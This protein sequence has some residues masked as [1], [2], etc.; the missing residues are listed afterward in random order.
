MIGVCCTLG[1]FAQ[2]DVQ[3]AGRPVSGTGEKTKALET[4]DLSG[5]S[6]GLGKRPQKNRSLLGNPLR[7]GGK[8]YSRGVGT[9]A[10]SLMY[11]KANGKV[12][13]FDALVGI[14]R[15]A[16][17]YP[18][19][20][21]TRKNWGCV[22]FRVYA[23]DR[24]VADSGVLRERDAPKRLH[25]NLAGAKNIVLECTDGGHWA[26]YMMGHGD[27]VDAY[28]TLGEGAV[29]EPDNT[30]YA[31]EQ[32]GILTPPTPA[33]PRINGA[34]VWGVRPGHPIIY[35]VPVSGERPLTLTAKGVPAGATFD[36]AKGILGGAVAKP[37]DYPIVVTAKNAKGTATRTITLKVGEKIC[38]TP[39]MGWNHWNI[40]T[41][42]V[43]DEK[44]RAAAQA[45]HT[46]GLGDHGWSYVNIDD[47]WQVNPKAGANDPS[48][49]GPE[50]LPDGTINPNRRFPDMKAL[51]DYIHSF[52]F[53]A[54]LYSSPG[55]YTCGGCTGSYRHELQDVQT[56]AKW[57][58]DYVKYDWCSYGKIFSAATKGR[59][60]TVDDYAK[61][62]RLLSD[63]IRQQNRDI[64]HAFCQY[65]MGN[66]QTWG[67]AAGA[68]VWR[69]WGD[70]KDSWTCLIKA[71]E[72]Y[73]DA[74]KYTKPGFW[75]DPDMM[76]LGVLSTANR[77]HAS[78]LTPNEQYTHM[79]LWCLLNAPLLLGNDL[80]EL[81]DFTK[82]LLVNDE[83]LAVNQ[84]PLGRQAGR[85]FHDRAT[86]IWSRPMANGDTVCGIV[87][88]FP[89]TRQVY[90]R[91]SFSG[92]SGTY[93]VRDLWRQKDVGAFKDGWR[94]NVPAHA[95]IV[96]RLRKCP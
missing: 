7:L 79:S 78:F 80:T 27:W 35:R 21:C 49:D 54:G 22:S 29:I 17:E 52:G 42:S 10:E 38:L 1:A 83:I 59:K 66:V 34:D 56:W 39:P 41:G 76:V 12:R 57:G 90:L 30:R 58:F 75:C 67:E 74:Y 32:L 19:S 63:A 4:F 93:Q 24:I 91:W 62:Y 45:M 47:W 69:S 44:I 26:G 9:H 68:N 43:S 5:A 53:K 25:A 86:D 82:S 14:D 64:V 60:P 55:P 88:R 31:K 15:E 8:T 89:F 77:R 84:D 37:G 50:R 6:C 70:L 36:A 81:D 73:A 40:W 2:G 3:G 87:N 71:T 94:V 96:V 20:W 33:E 51:A 85:V 92:L 61:P 46:S 18:A 23:D 72:S 65:G 95:T 11:F 16:Q 48:V 13:A 28:F